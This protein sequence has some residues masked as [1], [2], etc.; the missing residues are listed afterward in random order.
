MTYSELFKSVK[1]DY[2][3]FFKDFYSFITSIPAVIKKKKVFAAAALVIWVAV[4]IFFDNAVTNSALALKNNFLDSVFGFFHGLGKPKS[5]F[6]IIALLY[7]YGFIF[8]KRKGV[9]FAFKALRFFLY[10]GLIVTLLKSIIGRWRPFN[11]AGAHQFSP[12]T[13]GN[14][15]HLSLPSGD[16]AIIFS[17]AF[18]V[19]GLFNNTVWKWF[20]YSVALVTSIGRVYHYQHWTSDILLSFF[21]CLFIWYWDEKREASEK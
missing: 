19:Q 9:Y 2:A 14:N 5:V 20:C 7:A 18:A 4:F 15:A 11:G 6:I 17:M 1:D 21:I 13:F 3:S 16:A 8:I 10:S 12:F